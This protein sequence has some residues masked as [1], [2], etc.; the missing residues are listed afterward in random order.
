LKDWAGFTDVDTW[1]PGKRFV[2]S[3]NGCGRVSAPG[4]FRR[5]SGISFAVR[6]VPSFVNWFT[7][8]MLIASGNDGTTG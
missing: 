4:I 6:K 3:G 1:R 7:E 8:E 5:G 2:V